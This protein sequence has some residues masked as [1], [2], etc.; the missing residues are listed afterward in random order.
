VLVVIK[1][2]KLRFSDIGYI[3]HDDK[4]ISLELYSAGV[5]VDTISVNHLVCVSQGCMT[6][7]SFNQEYLNTNYPDD[8]IQNI[9]MRKPI[10]QKQ[11]YHKTE[12][13]FYQTIKSQNYSIQY[14]VQKKN[15]YFKDRKNHIIFKLKD[16]DE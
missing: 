13:G 12:D 14:K 10:F 2:P 1:S 9:L 7:N 4:S 16:I 5:A 8:F 11:G 6:K 3:R 15:L